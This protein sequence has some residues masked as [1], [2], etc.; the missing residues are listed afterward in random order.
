MNFIKKFFSGILGFLS[1]LFG[2]KKS[3]GGFYMQLDESQESGVT[4]KPQ[5]ASAPKP[6]KKSEPTSAQSKPA[7]KPEVT[8]TPPKQEKKP[9]P[10][11][12]PTQPPKPVATVSSQ[13]KKQEEESA[14][15]FATNY[16]KSV[17]I[18]N[19]PRRRPGPSLD[20]FRDMARQVKTPTA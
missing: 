9:E 8:S 5:T 10:A 13:Q 7:Q 18:P 20:T 17:S 3:E 2:G 14:S 4:N 12:T 15:T 16:L 1:G 11:T 6:E 19:Q